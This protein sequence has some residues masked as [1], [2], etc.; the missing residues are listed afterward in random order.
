MASGSSEG[1]GYLGLGDSV[2]R[3][4]NPIEIPALSNAS[5]LFLSASWSVALFDDT[6]SILVWGSDASGYLGNGVNISAP[7]PF[8][9]ISY[10]P[11]DV[12]LSSSPT[13]E[14]ILYAVDGV[15]CPA[16]SFS[17]DGF[18]PCQ[19]CAAGTY[20]PLAGMTNCRSCGYNATS[21]TSATASSDCFCNPGGFFQAEFGGCSACPTSQFQPQGNQTSCVDCPVGTN[22]FVSGATSCTGFAIV[23][24]ASV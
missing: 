1:R 8:T 17:S 22:A 24:S 16:G 12:F 7:R 4:W 20:Q 15:L 11:Y 23:G 5:S 19:P 2:S 10:P 18:A 6:N 9:N 13:E 14:A 21:A 3:T